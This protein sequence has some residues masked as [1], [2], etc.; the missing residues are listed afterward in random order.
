[1]KPKKAVLSK[2]SRLAA[3]FVD[4]GVPLYY[5]MATLLREM[6]V[7][8]R[9]KVGDRFPTEAEL[10]KEYGVSRITVREALSTLQEE[11]L[12]RRSAGK[13]TFVDKAPTPTDTLPMDGTLNGLIGMGLATA[14]R[15]IDL[16]EVEVAPHEAKVLGM[17]PGTPIVRAERIRYFKGRPYCYIVNHVPV[18]IG[19]QIKK[20]D[21]ERGSLLR[22]IEKSLG[23]ELG[24]ADEI[25][26][27]SLAD[28][29]LARW[30]DVR[31]GAPLLLVE[32]LIRASDGRPVETA[33]IYY[34][35]DA[36]LFALHL[37]RTAEGGEGTLDWAL[38]NPALR[39]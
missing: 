15:L 35:S 26:R 32:Y 9:F 1:M 24:D 38:R 17:E 36:H 37:T 13:G 28:A 25:V 19:R 18:E 4:G 30:L 23:I 34:R 6:I 7:S 22:L 8:G 14:P 27:A 16:R 10:V 2:Q 33:V 5:Q 39:S 29:H 11:E 31:I 3:E 20:S 12:I 21:W